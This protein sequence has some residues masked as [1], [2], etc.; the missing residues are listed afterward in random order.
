MATV[1]FDKALINLWPQLTAVQKEAVLHVVKS[2]LVTEEN[3][4]IIPE[5]G[6]ILSEYNREL[7][8]AEA[9]IDRGE[10]YTHEEVKK[11]LPHGT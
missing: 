8:E 5:L 6:T 4:K 3:E 1:A 9:E 10:F 2:Y 11:C 7:E